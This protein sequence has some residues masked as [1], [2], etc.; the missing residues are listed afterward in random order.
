MNHTTDPAIRDV[1][2]L[3]ASGQD[4]TAN[5]CVIVDPDGDLLLR[6]ATTSFNVCSAALRRAS[7]VFKAMLFGPWAESKPTGAGEQWVVSLPEDPPAAL[8][9]VLDIM[10]GKVD[11]VPNEIKA[12]LFSDMLVL[13]D[14]YDLRRLLRPW[15]RRWLE[16]V[17]WDWDRGSAALLQSAHIAW[18]VGLEDKLAI[19]LRRL[20]RGTS[21]ADVQDEVLLA[22]RVFEREP[23]LVGE[24]WF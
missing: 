20:V 24:C 9:I 3:P 13:T 6:T 10:H 15:T 12:S 1:L 21:K 14:K 23:G 22:S 16:K 2:P 8:E 11:V 4:T 17:G 19:I 5:R 18:E 7:P